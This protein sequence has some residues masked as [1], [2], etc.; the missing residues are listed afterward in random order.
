M[1]ILK[2]ENWSGKSLLSLKGVTA[3]A[4]VAATVAGMA[5]LAVSSSIA[6]SDK[7]VSGVKFEG[8]EIIPQDGIDVEYLLCPLYT[9]ED[10]APHKDATLGEYVR[11]VK[12][13]KNK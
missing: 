6:S 1:E 3:M 5:T 12:K 4:F 11:F 13:L 7:I 2:M 10:F 9:K 8:K